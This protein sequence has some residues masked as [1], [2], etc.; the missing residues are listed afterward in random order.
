MAVIDIDW[1]PTPKML[2]TF[3]LCGLVLFALLAGLVEWKHRIAFF[4]LPEAAVQ[5]TFYT[6]LALAAYC[7]FFA[8]IFPRGLYPF[9]VTLTVVFYP[10]GFVV[11]VI[12][13]L[14]LYFLVITPI[15]LVFKLI[16]K[17]PMNRRFEPQAPT[18]WIR[19]RPPE[20]VRRY[21]RQF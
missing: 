16:G 12:V 8:V 10:I 4:Q 7:G 1:K 9:Y 13:M 3:G 20:N 15:A 6:L 18:Y 5:P 11:S 21:F 14:A 2:R 19:R 17:D